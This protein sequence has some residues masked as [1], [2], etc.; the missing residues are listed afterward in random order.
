MCVYYSG[1]HN[2]YLEEQARR[3]RH[4]LDACPDRTPLAERLKQAGEQIGSGARRLQ[5]AGARAAASVAALL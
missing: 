4:V 1:Q 3:N 2:Q 5:E